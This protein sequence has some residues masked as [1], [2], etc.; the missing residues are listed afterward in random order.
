MT[1]LV[2]LSIVDLVYIRRCKNSRSGLGSVRHTKRLLSLQVYL[3]IKKS[4]KLS[5]NKFVSNS[6]MFAIRPLNLALQCLDVIVLSGIVSVL[7]TSIFL[8]SLPI[9]F[10]NVEHGL[11]KHSIIK[12]SREIHG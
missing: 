2:L 10:Y 11:I 8:E 5:C 1:D 6:G 3:S 4:D 7:H 9:S 12:N